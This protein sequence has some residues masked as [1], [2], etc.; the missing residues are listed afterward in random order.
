MAVTGI[1]TDRQ[2][3]I[4]AG[5]RFAV[6]VRVAREIAESEVRRS[7]A[8]EARARAAATS[9]RPYDE[10]DER[11]GAQNIAYSVLNAANIGIEYLGPAEADKSSSP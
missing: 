5:H 10:R 7:I 6:W 4:L 11:D 1:E 3:I 8:R 2:E 9:W